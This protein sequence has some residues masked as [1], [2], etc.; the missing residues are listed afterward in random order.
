M[1]LF[2]VV[3][4]IAGV[5]FPLPLLFFSFF[6]KMKT[7]SME[8]PEKAG[9]GVASGFERQVRVSNRRLLGV[10]QTQELAA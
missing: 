5:V 4:A 10:D 2:I 1:V 9:E 3:V 7:T 8:L 6:F